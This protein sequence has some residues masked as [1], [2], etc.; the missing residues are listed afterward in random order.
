MTLQG[1]VVNG[2]IVLDGNPPLAEGARVRV[3]YA[4]DDEFDD[5]APPPTTETYE[6]HLAILRQSIAEAKAGIPGRTVE[7]AMAEVDAELRRL[8]D[9]TG[10]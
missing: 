10:K 3:E 5:I 9:E 1:T 4:E 8:T 7:E 2:T 6:E